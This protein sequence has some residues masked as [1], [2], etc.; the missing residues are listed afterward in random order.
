MSKLPSVAAVPLSCG[1][2]LWVRGDPADL[3]RPGR[4]AAAGAD[5]RATSP[6]SWLGTWAS[7]LLMLAA[8][9]LT[10]VPCGGKL[11]SKL[12]GK[13]SAMTN[14]LTRL[15]ARWGA[16]LWLVGRVRECE[17]RRVTPRK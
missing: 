11:V 13:C 2:Q 7:W 4:R 9:L 17:V 5:T 8:E 16:A 15:V 6:Y 12:G 3:R 10:T 1:R 14:D